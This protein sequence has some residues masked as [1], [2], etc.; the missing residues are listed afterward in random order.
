MFRRLIE[1]DARAPRRP[2]WIFTSAGAHAMLIGLATALTLRQSPPPVERVILEDLVFTVPVH[3]HPLPRQ[4]TGS[5]A[6]S[7]LAPREISVT[8]PEIPEVSFPIDAPL[9]L[10]PGESMGSGLS[11]GGSLRASPGGRR[12]GLVAITGYGQ[13]EDQRRAYEAGFDAHL[14]KPVATERLKQVMAGLQ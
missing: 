13:A 9:R 12:M 7:W 8:I 4:E 11:P 5:G 1:S 2:G 14:T 3:R 10:L 6:P